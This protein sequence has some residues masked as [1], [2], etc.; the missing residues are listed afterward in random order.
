MVT[1]AMVLA[2]CASR[3]GAQ[4]T[5][6][7]ARSA[8]VQLANA[9]ASELYHCEPF[10]SSEAPHWNQGRWVWSEREGVGGGD[11]EAKVELA[12]DGSTNSV[13]VKLLDSRG[14]AQFRF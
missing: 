9:K 12:A 7:Q 11:M 13:D 5:A 1:I 3:K 2:G 14:I 10:S 6:E 8:A 4:L